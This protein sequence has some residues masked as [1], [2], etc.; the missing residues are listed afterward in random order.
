MT[1]DNGFL[2]AEFRRFVDQGDTT[3]LICLLTNP[4]FSLETMSIIVWALDDSEKVRSIDVLSYVSEE[5]LHEDYEDDKTGEKMPLGVALARIFSR[6]VEE[7]LIRSLFKKYKPEK[8][9]VGLM[10]ESAKRAF[11]RVNVENVFCLIEY[12]S[13]MPHELPGGGEYNYSEDVYCILV[14]GDATM[15]RTYLEKHPERAMEV[16]FLL[17]SSEISDLSQHVVAIVKAAAFIQCAKL[18]VKDI[19]DLFKRFQ[20]A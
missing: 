20:D 17:C 10:I 7:K 8:E 18:D 1:T 3:E 14:L 5:L 12:L 16:Y 2:N 13:S 19:D 9:L 4:S 15:M 6:N 11:A